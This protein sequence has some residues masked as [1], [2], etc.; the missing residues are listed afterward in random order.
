VTRR[1][2]CIYRLKEMAESSPAMTV[3]GQLASLPRHPARL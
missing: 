1:D 2:P 3:T